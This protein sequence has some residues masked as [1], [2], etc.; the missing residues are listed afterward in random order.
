MSTGFPAAEAAETAAAQ[1]RSNCARSITAGSGISVGSGSIHG[2]SAYPSGFLNLA[3]PRA[4]LLPG[5][6]R[7]LRGLQRGERLRQVLRRCLLA[8]EGRDRQIQLVE[9]GSLGRRD[10]A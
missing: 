10:V 8:L 4:G 7:A 5:E 2:E 6:Q 9:G 3:T 1:A